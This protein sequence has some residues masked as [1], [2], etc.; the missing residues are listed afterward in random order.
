MPQYQDFDFQLPPRL[1]TV[2]QYADN[3]KGNCNR[4]E[5]MF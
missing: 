3:K 5:I 2:A 4:S 1:E